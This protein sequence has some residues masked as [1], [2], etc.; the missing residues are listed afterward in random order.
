MNDRCPGCW[1]LVQVKF[2]RQLFVYVFVQH[3]HPK[4]E[5]LPESDDRRWCE[6]SGRPANQDPTDS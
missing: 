1:Q 2:D 5:H 3:T 4:R 6:F